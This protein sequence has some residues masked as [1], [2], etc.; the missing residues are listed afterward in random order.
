MSLERRDFL[1]EGGER[2]RRDRKS[3]GSGGPRGRNIRSLAPLFLAGGLLVLDVTIPARPTAIGQAARG[4]CVAWEVPARRA[5]VANPL[6]VSDAAIAEGRSIFQARCQ[7]CHGTRGNNDGP[8][9][10]L[11]QCAPRLSDAAMW[12]KTDG[13]LFWKISEGRAPMPAWKNVLTENQRWAVIH[14]VRTLSPKR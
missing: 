5:R 3:R 4:V 14:F 13:E 12:D 9:K 8:G 1:R 7:V 6:P 10:A 2:M 11:M